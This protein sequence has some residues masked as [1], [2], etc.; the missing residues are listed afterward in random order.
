M[1]QKLSLDFYV[2][3]LVVLGFELRTLCLAC[4]TACATPPPLLDLVI[5]EISSYIFLS[6]HL[7]SRCVSPYPIFLLRQGLVSY[8][9]PDRLGIM[10]LPISASCGAGIWQVYTI[11]PRY[12]LRWG[13]TNIL[14]R[15]GLELQS[16]GYLPPKELASLD[17]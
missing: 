7:C 10:I 5:F 8:F 12:C 16:S 2:F 14:P 6:S 9:C 1:C 11:A 15:V 13:L 4:C 17:F 3:F